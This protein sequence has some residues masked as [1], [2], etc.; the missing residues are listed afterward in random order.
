MPKT[1]FRKEHLRSQKIAAG[2]LKFGS[3]KNALENNNLFFLTTTLEF[4]D[5]TDKQMTRNELP[6]IKL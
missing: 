2:H 4:F 5:V 6:T 1:R 3:T